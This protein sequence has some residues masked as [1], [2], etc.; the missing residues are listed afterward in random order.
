MSYEIY[1]EDNPPF[2]SWTKHQTGLGWAAKRSVLPPEFDC[3]GFVSNKILARAISHFR[4]ISY[5][6]QKRRIGLVPSRHKGF[7]GYLAT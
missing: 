6:A 4:E 7:A 3:D 5:R 2:L 1:Y